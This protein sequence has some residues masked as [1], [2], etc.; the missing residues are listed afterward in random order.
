LFVRVDRCVCVYR[1]RK[2]RRRRR[3][4]HKV[5]YK[6]EKTIIAVALT[7]TNKGIKD[8]SARYLTPVFEEHI[9]ASTKIITDK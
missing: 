1:W 3:R 5:G 6:K 8:D 4:R 9:S 7:D 2:R